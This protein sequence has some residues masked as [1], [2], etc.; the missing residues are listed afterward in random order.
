MDHIVPVQMP[1]GPRDLANIGLGEDETQGQDTLTY[2]RPSMDIFKAI[3]A[4]NDEDSDDEQEKE[5]EPDEQL[6]SALQASILAATGSYAG[7]CS[8]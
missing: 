8:H 7:M 2:E 3:F 6:D 4:S 5:P 1:D